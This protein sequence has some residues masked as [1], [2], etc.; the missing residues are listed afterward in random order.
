MGARL[1]GAG[2]DVVMICR[3]DHLR[4]IRS[5]G[6]TLKIPGKTFNYAIPVVEHP[7]AIDFQNGDVVVLT[8]K[9][10]DTELAL[11][12]LSAATGDDCPV[13][14][15]QN[16]VENERIAI[17]RFSNVHGMVVWMPATY[18]EPGLVLN[19][20]TPVGGVLDC[21]RY[22]R[23]L[24]GLTSRVAKELTEAGFSALPND[25]IMRWKYSKLLRNL[26]NAFQAVCGYDARSRKIVKALRNEALACY[27]AAGIDFVS[28]LELRDRVQSTMKLSEIEGHPR[29]G[30]SSWQ[31]LTRGLQTVEADYLNGEIAMLGRAFNI[32]TPCNS[33]LQ[34][35]ANEM[36]RHHRPAGSCTVVEIEK[37]FDDAANGRETTSTW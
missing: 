14:C 17:R 2:H 25:N 37:R 21:G 33:L 15:A 3:G 27:K 7:K 12:D 35:L 5:S 36:A 4:T 11:R 19:H 23:G 34:A 6:L 32:K 10:Q 18:L 20:A 13:F 28:E 8:V 9:S 26:M 1:F 29:E 22:P 31:S 30:G 24:D 16:G